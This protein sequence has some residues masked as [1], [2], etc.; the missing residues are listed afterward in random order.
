MRRGS[1]MTVE[2][3]GKI[4]NSLKKYFQHTPVWNKGTAKPKEYYRELSRERRSDEKYYAK[5]LRDNAMRRDL[6]KYDEDRLEELTIANEQ[7]KRRIGFFGKQEWSDAEI[8]FLVNNYQTMPYEEICKQLK[9][10]WCSIIKK[11]GRLGLRKYNKY[12]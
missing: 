2:S 8:K 5:E 12:K 10:S 1:K 4:S 7:R 3:R 11:L 9:R 6:Y